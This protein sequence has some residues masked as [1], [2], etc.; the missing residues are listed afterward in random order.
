MFNAKLVKLLLVRLVFVMVL[1]L[2]IQGCFIQR[3]SRKARISKRKNERVIEQR[4][5]DYEKLRK[6]TVKQRFEL[7]TGKVQDRMKQSRKKAAKF[8]RK[9]QGRDSF[10]KRLINKIFKRDGRRN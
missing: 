5:V 1:M 7:Q 8:N 2:I 10:L 9:M 3:G 4:E 6:K